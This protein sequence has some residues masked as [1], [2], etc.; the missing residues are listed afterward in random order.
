MGQSGQGVLDAGRCE[1]VPDRPAS[2]RWI[3]CRC[4][5]CRSGRSRVVTTSEMADGRIV[6]E[7]RCALC[8]WRW[9]TCQEPEYVV[10]RGLVVYEGKRAVMR[11]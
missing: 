11:R 2:S 4:P 7:R 9:F 8:D 6:R 3:R 5:K 10:E 1:T